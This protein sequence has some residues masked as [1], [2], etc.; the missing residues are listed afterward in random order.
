M[1]HIFSYFFCITTFKN[2]TYTFIHLVI[3]ML[4][5]GATWSQHDCNE[6]LPSVRQ[7]LVFNLPIFKSPMPPIFEDLWK[8]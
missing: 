1:Q 2:N 4:R 7:M 8:G 3:H 5:H 6:F